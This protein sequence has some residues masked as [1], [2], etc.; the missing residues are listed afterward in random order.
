MAKIKE[1]VA[2]L[3][4]LTRGLNVNERSAEGK[5]LVNVVDV[6]SYVAEEIEVLRLAHDDLENYV[7]A[8]DED[9][10]ELEDG[11]YEGV[12]NDD[13]VELECPS[14]HEVVTFEANVLDEDDIVE[15]TCPNCGETI[16]E[17]TIEFSDADNYDVA[18]RRDNPGL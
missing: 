3:Q 9:L 6:L 7:E 17:N 1:K 11:V 2:Y 10:T 14:C 16:Y 18:F 15:V 8:I 12:Y 5:L 4:G 13:M